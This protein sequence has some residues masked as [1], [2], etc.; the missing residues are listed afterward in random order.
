M[1]QN[2]HLAESWLPTL[3]R[4]CEEITPD[5]TADNFRLWLTAMPSDKFP[6]SILQ[7]GVKVTLEPPKGM[8]AN[9][10]GTV[11]A[12]RPSRS[13]PPS[14]AHRCSLGF[15][16]HT[17]THART[18]LSLV[19]LCAHST[20]HQ[21]MPCAA[22]CHTSLPTR[23]VRVAHRHG[24][25]VRATGSYNALDED[26]FESSSR[27]REFKKMVFGLCFFHATVRE[28]SKFGPL[29]WNIPYEFSEPDLRISLDQVRGQ[30]TYSL[31]P[32]P[33]HVSNFGLS[34]LMCFELFFPFDLLLFP[35]RYNV[36]QRGRLRR[37][38]LSCAAALPPCS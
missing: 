1:S 27:P 38:W 13:L 28:R 8:R 31:A 20:Q 2:C 34:L 4:M 16:P 37:D 30:S 7:S 25:A 14:R 36:A 10:T 21:S 29:G 3:E 32:H 35:S 9:L 15:S 12:A 5:N 17:S 23:A 6:V 19:A 11:P 33:R 18:F 22:M 26:W 24:D